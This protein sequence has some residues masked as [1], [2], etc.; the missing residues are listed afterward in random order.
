MRAVPA[1]LAIV[2]VA[3]FEG[4][5]YAHVLEVG[6]G[7]IYA[8]PCMAIG[9][10]NANDEI[11]DAPGTYTDSCE[12]NTTGLT[13]KGVGGQPKIDLSGTNHP[14]D[15]KGIY[16]VSADNVT[17]ANLELTGAHVDDSE[18]G[19]AAGLRIT[20]HGVTV[21]GCNIHDNQNGIL[22]APIVDG[23]TITIEYTEL[24]HNGLCDAC[25]QGGC[26]HN[27]YVS[28]A[29]SANSLRQDVVF[30]FNWSHD[31][32]SD[33]ADKGHLLQVAI[34][35]DRRALQS[36]HGRDRPRQLRGRHSQRG[37]RD[38]RRQRDREGND[39]RRRHSCV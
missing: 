31:L 4:M 25:D 32:A 27:V 1:L 16:V 34:A 7:K 37:P 18:G 3:G 39:A 6:P 21:H 17:I 5:A 10:A 9:V 28:K 38:R 30:Q 36:H 22:A 23:G 26:V 13:V 11:D 24:S 29:S 33:T 14:A 2:S 20:G 12:V 19:N 15:Y 8:T 35:R